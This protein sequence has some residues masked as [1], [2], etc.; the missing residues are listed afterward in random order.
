MTGT[1]AD[2]GTGGGAAPDERLVAVARELYGRPRAEFTVAR[3]AAAR[4][5]RAEGAKEVS[6]AV[7]RLR[8][9]SAAAW[10]V[11]LLVRRR[12]DEVREL[13]G[14]GRGLRAA[15]AAL[16]GPELRE[17]VATQHRLLAAVREGLVADVREAGTSLSDALAHEAEETVRAAMGDAGAAAALLTGLLVRTLEGSGL[18]AVDVE[19]AVAVPGAP[20]LLDVPGATEAADAAEPPAAPSPATGSTGGAEPPGRDEP[21]APGA[22]RPGG[23][24]R[25]GRDDAARHGSARGPQEQAEHGRA[26]RE[27]AERERAERERAEQERAERERAEQDRAEREAEQRRRRERERA[28]GEESAA[29]EAAEAASRARAD[30]D[31]AVAEARERLDAAAAEVATLARRLDAARAAE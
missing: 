4:A 11:D 1:G 12:P 28:L 21:P 13:L 7:G 8:A 24:R 16:A 9:P 19:G 5:L 6:A 23:R 17:L 3:T 25:A 15:Q 27:R 14:L 2:A 31:G 26:E 22:T 18:T 20:P 29:A 30:A 10:A